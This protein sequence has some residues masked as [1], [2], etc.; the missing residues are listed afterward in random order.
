MPNPPIEYTV[1]FNDD[2]ITRL[3]ELARGIFSRAT[4]LLAQEVWGNIGREA[5]TDHG[6]LAGSFMIEAM[7]EFDWR[8]YSNVEY[9]LWVHEGTGVYGP[10]GQP[11]VPV[12]ASVLVFEAYGKT[13]FLKSVQGQEP[14]PYADRAIATAD[15]RVQEFVTTALNEMGGAG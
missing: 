9:S 2:D 3:T 8:I 14:N 15:S 10:R 5:P 7:N 12:T 4:E 11:I 13:W 6:R 1:E